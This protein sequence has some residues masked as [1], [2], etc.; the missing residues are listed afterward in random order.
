LA[1]TVEQI[2]ERL[3]ILDVVGMYIKVEKAGVN[4]KARCPFH[5]EKSPSFFLSPS[6]NTF[7]CFGCGAKGDIFEFVERFEGLDFLGSMKLLAEKAGVTISNERGDGGDEK[8]LLF[9]VLELATI[10][11]EQNLEENEKAQAYLTERG[12]TEETIKKFRLGYAP[13]SWRALSEHL[14]S[15]GV[16]LAIIEKAGLSKPGNHGAYDRFRGR[17]MFPIQDGSG[18]VVAYSGRIFD[19][20]LEGEGVTPAKYVNSPETPL[21]HKSHIL[22]GF[23]KAKEGIRKWTFAIVV[24]GQMDLLMSHQ[25]GFTNT[26]AL[27]GTAL[28]EEQ[29]TL[30]GRLTE[31]LVLAL[32]A[33]VAG[34]SASGK[35]ASL[36][37]SKGFDVKVA[38]LLGG[39][40]PAEIVKEDPEHY[41]NN[42][43][44]AKH[45]IE[46]YLEVLKDKNPDPRSYKL[47]VTK[48]VLPFVLLVQNAVD[49]AHFIG[50]VALHMGVPQRAIEEE[51]M[52]LRQAGLA[53][54]QKEV[55]LK[56]AQEAEIEKAVLL[57]KD[58]ILLHLLGL[59]VSRKKG[60]EELYE[61]TLSEIELLI[62]KETLTP[63]FE[64]KI[65]EEAS[66]TA[67]LM[68]DTRELSHIVKQLTEELALEGMKEKSVLLQEAIRRNETEGDAEAL[69]MAMKEYQTLA[70]EIQKEEQ[71]ISA[72]EN[73][74]TQINNQAPP[75]KK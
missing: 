31:R 57:R 68:N 55:V 50:V 17:I 66:F 33:D 60:N 67:E 37:L 35:S 72:Y 42:I 52:K 41:K 62:G 53:H 24:E 38:L 43:R 22:Y 12:L 21:F 10:F 48:A 16:D 25:A 6:R 15:K 59:L 13:A 63:Y 11:F 28:T 39:K 58:R 65:L 74:F 14:V 18:R 54:P 3:T 47:S 20:T 27:S 29:L 75:E 44:G 71:K 64:G 23:D 9:E 46:F 73:P 1:S 30:L 7:Y 4:F 2:K 49:R 51:L 45:I 5:H 61:K 36:S 69:L 70:K 8:K 56:V 40:D 32:D 34:L 19:T 26:V